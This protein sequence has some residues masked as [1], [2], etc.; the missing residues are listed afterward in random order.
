MQ[1]SSSTSLSVDPSRTSHPMQHEWA[2]VQI[3]VHVSTASTTSSV[4][5]GP[6]SAAW[7]GT[8]APDPHP[9]CVRTRSR[10]RSRDTCL[11]QVGWE[12]SGLGREATEGQAHVQA[13]SKV[14]ERHTSNSARDACV[15]VRRRKR[16]GAGEHGGRRGAKEGARGEEG[17]QRGCFASRQ[18]LHEVRRLW[19]RIRRT[20]AL[21]KR[22]SMLGA[23]GIHSVLLQLQVSQAPAQSRKTRERPKSRSRYA[24]CTCTEPGLPLHLRNLAPCS[25]ECYG[26][27]CDA[28]D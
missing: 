27:I 7:Y 19:C 11:R 18:F 8:D 24:F 13:R 28:S 6:P 21:S 2:D 16:K 20:G 15:R 10:T 3:Q 17:S 22:R 23:H 12:R 4:P 14:R 9:G 5:P 1:A 25:S 26:S